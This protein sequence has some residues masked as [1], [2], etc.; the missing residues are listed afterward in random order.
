MKKKLAASRLDGLFQALSSDIQHSVPA[1]Q[2]SRQALMRLEDRLKKKARLGNS[3]LSKKAIK[4][5]VSLNAIVKDTVISIDPEVLSNARYFIQVSIEGYNSALDGSYPQEVLNF[6]HLYDLWYFGP[7]ASFEVKGTHCAEKIYEPMTVTVLAESFVRRLRFLQPYM[8]LKDLS[9]NAG[10]REVKGSKMT[11]VPKNELT[12]RT[13]AVE[14]SGNMC[15]QLAV[16]TYIEGILRRIGLD[17]TNQAA[18]NNQLAKKASTDN[19]LATIDL[20]SASD[21]IKPDLVRLLFPRS[22]FELFMRLRSPCTVLPSGEELKLNMISTMGNGYTF[23]MMTLILLSLIYGMRC[24]SKRQKRTLWIEWHKTAV[25]GDDIIVPSSEYKDLCLVLESAG[26]IINHD[27]SFSDGPFRESCG[28]DYYLGGNITPFYV[29]QLTTNSEVY[30]AINQIL[31]YCGTHE[32]AFIRSLR[33][34]F[35]LLPDSRPFV[36]PE[37]LNPDQGLLASSGPRRYKYL[38]VVTYTKK[39]QDDFFMMSLASGGYIFPGRKLDVLYAPRTDNPRYIVKRGR[40][41]EGFSNGWDAAKRSHRSSNWI[42]LLIQ[43]V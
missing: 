36:V 30:V 31:D 11:T 16:G 13:I 42:D 28:G 17:I 26:F 7:G 5:F 15:M 32:L 38:K 1:C 35:S 41:P 8:R 20:K 24:A 6:Q 40:I 9:H 21:V 3:D 34:L 37:W 18:K 23:P 12:E 19:S 27:K 2:T 43:L 39:L 25:F 14:P 4:D 33:Y 22:W 29:K 10:I